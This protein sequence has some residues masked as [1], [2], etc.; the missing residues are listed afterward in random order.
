VLAQIKPQPAS[1][2]FREKSVDI[3]HPTPQAIPHAFTDLPASQPESGPQPL[4]HVVAD[5]E[6]LP[7]IAQHY[8]RDI[9]LWPLIYQANQDRL[10]SPEL[11]PVG[12]ELVIPPNP[13]ER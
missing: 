8:Y 7:L 1:K 13:R 6:T 4:R 5:G 3:G 9:T 12:T 10:S 11:L 2:E